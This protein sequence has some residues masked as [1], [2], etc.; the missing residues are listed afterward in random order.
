MPNRAIVYCGQNGLLAC[1]GRCD[2]AWGKSQ[3]PRL[4]YQEPTGE[5]RA[6]R[7]GEEPRD[8]DDYVYAS[9][10]VLGTAPR[11]PGTAEGDE[12]KPSGEPLTQADAHRM[13]KWC[14]R[15]CERA[16]LSRPNTTI[17]NLKNLRKPVPNILKRHGNYRI[18]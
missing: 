7:E 6:L 14:A 9:D 15:E 4:Y 2:K 8:D 12:G 18:G 3:R 1:D 10:D 13:N 16:S 17:V 5:P 11:D